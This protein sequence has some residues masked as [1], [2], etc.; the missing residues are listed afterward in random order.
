MGTSTTDAANANDALVAAARALE[1]ALT[2]VDLPLA[3][4]QAERARATASAAAAEL[5]DYI[6]PRLANLDAPALVVVGG[7]TGAGKSTLVNSVVG[8]DVTVPGVLR[9]TTRAPVLICHPDAVHWFD[10][11]RILPGLARVQGGAATGTSEIQLVTNP[12]LGPDLALI[13][14]PDIDS[15]VDSNRALAAELLSAADMWVFVTTAVRYADAVPWEFL[16]TARDRGTALIVVLNRVPRGAIDEVK[17]DLA[18]NLDANGLTGVEIV[19]V[20]EQPL[21]QGHIPAAAVQSLRSWLTSLATN[22]ETRARIVRQ[23]LNGAIGD[24][25]GRAKQ[26]HEGTSEQDRA[27]SDLMARAKAPYD[28]A[29][30]NVAADIR[31]GSV[32]RGEVLAR[33]QELV[34][35]GELLRSLQSTLGRLRDRIASAVTGRKSANDHFQGAVESGVDTL[36]RARLTEAAQQAYASWRDHPAGHALLAAA[37]AGLDQPTPGLSEKSAR[38][39]RDWQQGLIELLKAEGAGK[40]GAA[41]ALSYGVNGL[42]A[43]LMVGV[44]AH[45][46]GLTGAE[47]AIAGGGSVVGQ[48]LLEAL[49][50]D[51]AVRTLADKARTDLDQRVDALAAEE[52]GRYEALLGADRAE[53]SKALA[54]AISAVEAART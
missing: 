12:A 27:M 38:L 46:G 8:A 41:K 28:A 16:H 34:G 32:L 31:E 47:L 26:V 40:K 25:L 7:S 21:D 4:P 39:V 29:S 24:L 17:A 54:A 51:Q 43:I 42:A 45:T 9:P 44:F 19:A 11:T 14:A 13:D 15:V 5:R 10:T 49:L 22:H 23:S 33:W 37:P 48:K 30:D 50:G 1:Q 2:R 18:A 36:L 52:W 53:E 6:I 3:L 20:E 35:G